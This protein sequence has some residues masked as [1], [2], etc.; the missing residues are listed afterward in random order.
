[1]TGTRRWTAPVFD[2]VCIVVFIALGRDQHHLGGG[3]SWFLTVLWPLATGWIVGS[4]ATRLYTRPERGW[5][6]L[7]GTLAIAVVIGGLLRGAF[8]GRPTFSTFTIVETVFLGATTF[9]WRALA[10]A[11]ARRRRALSAS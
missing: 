9:A 4:L 6:R 3:V 10:L 2:A 5:A 8:T 1:M 7:L 11:L